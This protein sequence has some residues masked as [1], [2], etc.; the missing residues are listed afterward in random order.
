MYLSLS[1]ELQEKIKENLK[2]SHILRDTAIRRDQNHDT[3]SL[4]RPCFLRDVEKIMHSPY[5]NRYTDKTQ[6]FA[7]YKNDDISRR[8]FHVQL[9]SR[10]ARNIGRILGLDLDLIEAIALGHDIGHTPFGHAGEHFLNE[11]SSEYT[12]RFFHHNVHSV[13]VLDGIFRHNISLQTLDG[14]LCHNGEIEQKE[15]RP[16]PLSEFSEFDRKTE[17]CYLEKNAVK[18]LI[19]STMEGCVV[20]ICDMIAYLGKDRQDAFKTDILDSEAVFTET[21][22]GKYNAAI[23]NNLSV[24]IIE[25]SYGKDYICM[26]EKYYKALSQIK[27]ENYELIYGS[28]RVKEIEKKLHPMFGELYRKLKQDLLENRTASPIFTHHLDFIEEHGKFYRESNYRETTSAD[29]TVID[30]IASMTDDYFIELYQYLF[31]KSKI[32]LEYTPYFSQKGQ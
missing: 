24:N 22:L 29:Q 23:I 14:I 2:D 25:N 9:V 3:A 18:E 12:G 10:I 16:A 11:L 31:P 30:Y 21:E 6:V 17:R 15:Y 13:R 5:Y 28:K 4:W 26:D 32:Q 27:A 20:R 7:F 1:K 8:A 19:P